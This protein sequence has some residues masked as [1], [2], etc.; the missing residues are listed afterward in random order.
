L[1][2]ILERLDEISGEFFSLFGEGDRRIAFQNR[3]TFRGENLEIYSDLRASLDLIVSHL[4]VLKN[5][6]DEVGPLI[7]RTVEI[8][9]G[10]RFVMEEEDDRFVFWLER[11]GRGTFLQATPIGWP[12]FSPNGSSNKWIP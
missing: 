9:N 8:S 10:L 6:P 7:R 5:P 4:R 12:R 3:A 1:D 2:R 11:R